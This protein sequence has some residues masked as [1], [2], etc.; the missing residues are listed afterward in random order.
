MARNGKNGQNHWF[1]WWKIFLNLPWDGFMFLW[2]YWKATIRS[3]LMS[4]VLPTL[5]SWT[6][7]SLAGWPWRCR[8]PSVS[9]APAEL[10]QHSPGTRLAFHMGAGD[11]TQV[12]MLVQSIL[13]WLFPQPNIWHFLNYRDRNQINGCQTGLGKINYFKKNKLHR[14]LFKRLRMSLVVT[15]LYGS[16]DA[17]TQQIQPY[18]RLY[19]N[20]YN[21]F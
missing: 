9:R 20:K 4:P 2:L 12:F 21:R 18:I 13:C 1:A 16:S 10:R 5:L 11:Q 3:H 7:S 14:N 19:Y 6:Y 8:D 15:D 17:G